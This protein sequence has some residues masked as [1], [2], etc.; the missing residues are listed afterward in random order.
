MI[1]CAYVFVTH[2]KKRI[3][4]LLDAV[5]ISLSTVF[6]DILDLLVDVVNN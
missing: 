2:F 5:P 1:V 4:F 3:N 6:Q